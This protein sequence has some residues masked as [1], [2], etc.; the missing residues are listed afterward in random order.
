ML[1]THHQ[2]CDHSSTT[3]VHADTPQQLDTYT[4]IDNATQGGGGGGSDW[5]SK[6]WLSLT[7]PGSLSLEVNGPVARSWSA[8]P[9]GLWDT[10]H[11]PH[12]AQSTRA[13]LYK[14]GFP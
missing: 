1:L 7:R 5:R 12:T 14:Q 2:T 3:V 8:H 6:F 10:A 9:I 13:L 4:M 11:K